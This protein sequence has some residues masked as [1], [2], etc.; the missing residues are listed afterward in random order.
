MGS[1]G[2][3]LHRLDQSA[4][5]STK[6]RALHLAQRPW[7]VPIP[8][9]RKLHRREEKLAATDVTL[10]NDNLADLNRI[11]TDIAIHGA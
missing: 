1:V 6:P 3:N 11:S 5:A 10:S 4:R 9:T 7:I 8:G 2:A